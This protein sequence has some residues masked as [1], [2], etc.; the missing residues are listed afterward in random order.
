[1]KKLFEN[2]KM[3]RD[4]DRVKI[5]HL[6]HFSFL[7][8]AYLVELKSGIIAFSFPLKVIFAGIIYRL[9]YKMVKNLYYSFW[10]FSV[11]IFIYL[12]SNFVMC[13]TFDNSFGLPYIYLLA[14]IS[15]LL[16]CYILYSPIYYP[17]VRWWEYDFRYRHD[18]KV[19]ILREEEK[20]EGRFTDL[21]RGAGCVLLF[22][23][24]SIGDSLTI[25]TTGEIKNIKLNAEIMAKHEYM[26]GRGITYGVKFHFDDKESKQDF[27][28]FSKYWSIERIEKIQAKYDE[29]RSSS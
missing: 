8:L 18:L 16:E 21:R 25:E 6:M 2:L 10:T 27:K 20:Y 14:M 11:L 23:D 4:Y 19:N 5:L 9:Y 29:E 7:I 15:L 17:R 12:F 26:V 24:L 22:E 13:L 3:K 1:M 28:R